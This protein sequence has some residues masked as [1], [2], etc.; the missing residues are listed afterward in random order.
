M[1]RIITIGRE[2]GSGGRT[3]GKLV[4]N[5]LGVAYYDNELIDKAAKKTG[6]L[7]SANNQEPLLPEQVF[8]AQREVIE[9]IAQRESCVIVVRGRND[10]LT[11][12]DDVLKVFIYADK[13][14]REGR[15]Q[16][17]NTYDNRIWGNRYNYDLML[18]SSK[19][20]Y[21]NCARIICTLAKE[22]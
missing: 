17:H 4:A 20:G 8:E 16:H 2:P 9:A 21:E 19:I 1:K 15:G 22:I 18:D 13:N 10:I 14:S 12:R 6:I 3:I 11:D 5:R 7:Q